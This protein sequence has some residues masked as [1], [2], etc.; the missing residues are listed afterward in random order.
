MFVF[1]PEFDE[2][3]IFFIRNAVK[4]FIEKQKNYE[5][6]GIPIELGLIEEFPHMKTLSNYLEN[7]L[8][9][10]NKECQGLLLKIVPIVLNIL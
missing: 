8:M 10:E 1:D 3:M 4:N 9:K 7:F 2:G 6:N 5:I